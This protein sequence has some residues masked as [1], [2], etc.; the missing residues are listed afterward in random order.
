MAEASLAV[1]PATQRAFPASIA[2]RTSAAAATAGN[3]IERASSQGI[4]FLVFV[5]SASWDAERACT[6]DW[7]QARI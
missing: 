5:M 4:H 7:V 6:K 3:A 2:F 1:R